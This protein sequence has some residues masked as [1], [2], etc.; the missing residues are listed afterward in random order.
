MKKRDRITKYILNNNHKSNKFKLNQEK[1][2]EYKKQQS[3]EILKDKLKNQIKTM[4]FTNDIN[5]YIPNKNKINEDKQEFRNKTNN[6][7]N[8]DIKQLRIN[9][10][11]RNIIKNYKYKKEM[12]KY[13]E[14]YKQNKIK[15][16]FKE[17][18]K[19]NNNNNNSNRKFNK[20]YDVNKKNLFVDFLIER[21]NFISNC[22]NVAHDSFYLL[23]N[24][25]IIDIKWNSTKKLNK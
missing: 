9:E 17:K 1:M 21:R 22:Y 25:D 20:K 19:N 5:N 10:I 3:K 23:F 24:N 12:I 2:I 14:L 4:I 13:Y 8:K 18:I 7:D 6:K 15:E 11:K 16:E